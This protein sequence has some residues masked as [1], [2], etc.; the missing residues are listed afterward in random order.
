MSTELVFPSKEWFRAAAELLHADTAVQAA[1]KDFGAVTVG[2]VIEKGDGLKADFCLFAELKPGLPP[3]L[4]FPDDEDELEE[5]EPQYL[6]RAPHAVSRRVVEAVIAGTQVD[7]LSPVMNREVKL[8]GDLA[9]LVRFAGGPHRSA[10]AGVL[11]RLPTRT[12][13]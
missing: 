2:A 10:G 5:M 13:R 4:Q 12:L 6:L 3:K 7:P 9:R 11:P 1:A 8:Q